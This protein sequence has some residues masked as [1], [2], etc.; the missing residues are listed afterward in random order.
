MYFIFDANMPP[1]LVTG[2]EA[3]DQ[4]NSSN[5]LKIK[6]VHSDH[7]LNIGATDVEIIRKAGKLGAIIISQDDDFKR[8]KLNKQLVKKL[9][10]GYV[11]YKPPTHG[12]RYWEKVQAFILGWERLKQKI[13]EIEKPFVLIINKKGDI[14][15]EHL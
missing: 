9:K 10:V 11:L 5:A 8:I 13:R 14:S 15:Q 2:L 1:K 7:L 12:A 3:L 6:I 4:E